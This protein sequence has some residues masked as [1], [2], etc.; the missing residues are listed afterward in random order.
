MDL[1]N[2]KDYNPQSGKKATFYG[3]YFEPDANQKTAGRI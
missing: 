2:E 1:S 3:N